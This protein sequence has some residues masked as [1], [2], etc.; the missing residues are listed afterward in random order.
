V[1]DGDNNYQ[2]GY[3]KPPRQNQFAKGRSGNP[4]GRRKGAKNMSTLLTEACQEKVTVNR[5]GRKVKM[6]K[7]SASLH[8]LANKAATGDLK[9][10]RELMYWFKVLNEAMQDLPSSSFYDENDS[11][12]VT[13]ILKRL[14]QC[15]T[16]REDS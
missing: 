2:V 13:S 15:E 3:G 7:M 10:I 1:A 9:A 4:S 11:V 6:T 14:R 12:V 5:N 16:A 8:Q